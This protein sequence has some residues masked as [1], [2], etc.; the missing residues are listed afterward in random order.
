MKNKIDNVKN[1]KNNDVSLFFWKISST[2][3]LF[4]QNHL[5]ICIFQRHSSLLT[6]TFIEASFIS[7]TTITIASSS[8]NSL[9]LLPL[10]LFLDL[11][12]HQLTSGNKEK[13]RSNIGISS[14]CDQ[15]IPFLTLTQI[16]ALLHHRY[17]RKY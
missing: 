11:N 16:V 15:K 10:L 14:E 3:I 4:Y 5:T 1:I 17:Y 12:H 13:E 8:F 9:L 7:S 2:I 6:I